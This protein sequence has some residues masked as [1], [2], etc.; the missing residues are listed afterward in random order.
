MNNLLCTRTY[1]TETLGTTVVGVTL[2]RD[3]VSEDTLSVSNLTALQSLR[4]QLSTWI[5]GQ[6]WLT[7]SLDYTENMWGEENSMARVFWPNGQQPQTTAP[8]VSD[9]RPGSESVSISNTTAGTVFRYATFQ[10]HIDLLGPDV[11][12]RLPTMSPIHSGIERSPYTSLVDSTRTMQGYLYT[13]P[14][15]PISF[16]WFVG[17]YPDTQY[18][19]QDDATFM[20]I[21]SAQS[22]YVFAFD[23]RDATWDGSTHVGVNADGSWT[24]ATDKV[25]FVDTN[26]TF[27]PAAFATYVVGPNRNAIFSGVHADTQEVW[28]SKQ[29]HE[30][31]MNRGFN[32]APLYFAYAQLSADTIAASEAA[33]MST[34][35]RQTLLG[36][37]SYS[38]IRSTFQS[39]NS[40]E[41]LEDKGSFQLTLQTRCSV[42][43]RVDTIHIE[44]RSCDY[45]ALLWS[46]GTE[47]PV[48]VS[49]GPVT[50]ITQGV[51]K[52]YADTFLSATTLY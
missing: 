51:R 18:F 7:P 33:L 12:H 13:A 37:M 19:I 36:T 47:A 20:E 21:S 46:V 9:L 22:G 42:P 15:L 1:T 24:D 50:L 45:E 5:E 35:T 43:S 49:S 31:P 11:R 41:G 16:T 10:S 32:P 39:T 28:S 25:T 40:T 8:V 48:D 3:T 44:F 26:G 52:G 23:T 30:A 17:E 6:A 34:H 4:L 38:M 27:N 14:N 29:S 2:T